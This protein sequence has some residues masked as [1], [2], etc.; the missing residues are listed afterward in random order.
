MITIPTTETHLKTVSRLL[1][2]RTF[3][4]A[5]LGL[6][7]LAGNAQAYW[8]ATAEVFGP[9]GTWSGEA[10]WRNG[11]EPDNCGQCHAEILRAFPQFAPIVAMHLSDPDGTPMHAL[12]NGRHFLARDDRETAARIWRCAVEDLPATDANASTIAAFVDAQ[13]QRWADESGQAWALLDGI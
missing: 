9:H 8:T 2:D 5:Q 13:R 1:P 4:L 11:R 12:A 10:C 3:V 6:H 7:K